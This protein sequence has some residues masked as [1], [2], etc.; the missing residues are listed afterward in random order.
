[1]PLD[2]VETIAV[3]TNVI[4]KLIQNNQFHIIGNIPNI[5]FVVPDEV[6]A[7]VTYPEQRVKALKAISDG[8]LQRI[9]ITDQAELILLIE[10]SRRVESGEAACLA[11]AQHRGYAI[12]SDEKRRFEREAIARIGKSRLLRTEDILARAREHKLIP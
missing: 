12:V 3:D 1:M 9:S 4:I 10:I 2:A 6:V 11:I 8:L 7:E 5:H